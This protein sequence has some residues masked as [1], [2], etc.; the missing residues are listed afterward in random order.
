MRK[1]LNI[2]VIGQVQGVGFRFSVEKMAE[3]L[4]LFGFVR[5]EEG[6]NVYIEAEG[7]EEKLDE[8]INW[9]KK[10]PAWAKVEKAEILEGGLKNFQQFNIID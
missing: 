3:S 1:H 10:G 7:E 5:N 8:F 6:G 4:Q 9:C 2:K